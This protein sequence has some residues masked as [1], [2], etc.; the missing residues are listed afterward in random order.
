MKLGDIQLRFLRK[1]DSEWINLHIQNAL[2]HRNYNNPARIDSDK[3]KEFLIKDK[4]HNIN[5][6]WYGLNFTPSKIKNIA[7]YDTVIQKNSFEY[8]ILK[9]LKLL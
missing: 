5:H 3:Y 9:D 2:I 7:Y 1:I 8:K 4:A 6:L